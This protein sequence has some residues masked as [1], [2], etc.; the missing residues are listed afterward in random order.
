M[1]GI[2]FSKPYSRLFLLGVPPPIYF[3]AFKFLAAILSRTKKT[4]F[5]VRKKKG[6]WGAPGKHQ[7]RAPLTQGCTGS[8]DPSPGGTPDPCTPI[9]ST[10][11]HE[12]TISLTRKLWRDTL[13]VHQIRAP[14]SYTL[15]TSLNCPPP[16]ASIATIA[17]RFD[18][19]FSFTL[20]LTNYGLR[21]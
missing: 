10:E 17:A 12:K 2:A 19:V 5:S 1:K 11:Q 15:C 18:S 4:I 14:P 16:P 21:M 9:A 3:N 13:G 6:I 20:Q 8:V 7:I